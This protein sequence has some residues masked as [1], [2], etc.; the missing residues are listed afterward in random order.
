MTIISTKLEKPVSY[1]KSFGIRSLKWFGSGFPT[2]SSHEV[3]VTQ[4]IFY[5]RTG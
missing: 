2:S 1:V 3:V 5:D 4:Y